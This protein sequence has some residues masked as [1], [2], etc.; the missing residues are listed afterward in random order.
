MLCPYPLCVH[1]NGFDIEEEFRSQ[2]SGV[3][4]NWMGIQTLTNCRQGVDGGNLNPFIS[5]C[6]KFATDGG[7]GELGEL[8]E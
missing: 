3:R 4:I 2:N 5:I 6:F 7:L 1:L 8:G